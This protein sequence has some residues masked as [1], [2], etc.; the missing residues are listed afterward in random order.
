MQPD[1][2][3]CGGSHQLG[4]I[5]GRRDARS[6]KVTLQASL[7]S[8]EQIQLAF[9]TTPFHVHASEYVDGQEVGHH[10]RIVLLPRAFQ[11]V[12][13]QLIGRSEVIVILRDHGRRD[14]A[15]ERVSCFRCQFLQDKLHGEIYVLYRQR[16]SEAVQRISEIPFRAEQ[17]QAA[18]DEPAYSCSGV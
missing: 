5:R 11:E 16:A 7:D 12:L 4:V 8:G 13:R 18:R 2:N 15:G 14:Y 17:E 6:P 9:V 1:A 10:I 3:H